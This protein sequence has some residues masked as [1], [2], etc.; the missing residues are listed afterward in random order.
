[1]R[2]F[3]AV[4]WSAPNLVGAQQHYYWSIRWIWAWVGRLATWGCGQAVARLVQIC[5]LSS[6]ELIFVVKNR[7]WLRRVI[8]ISG[9]PVGSRLKV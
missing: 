7:F 2:G 1:M 4:R 5:V 9:G 3:K 6:P 8:F